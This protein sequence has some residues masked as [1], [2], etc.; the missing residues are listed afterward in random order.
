MSAVIKSD[1]P[2]FSPYIGLFL[3]AY[4]RINHVTQ[5]TCCQAH[6]LYPEE[7][8][9]R[10]HHPRLACC[11]AVSE[12][13]KRID[14][15]CN[16]LWTLVSRQAWTSLSMDVQAGHVSPAPA[17]RNEQSVEEKWC[18]VTLPHPPLGCVP[19]TCCR[20]PLPYHGA[21]LAL[22]V[23]CSVCNVT[24]FTVGNEMLARG[25]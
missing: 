3:L 6:H 7:E 8:N 1:F 2:R 10:M 15:A 13:L 17:S 21:A 19:I 11:K 14:H 18:G 16:H 5:E 20:L 22:F 4:L 12:Q 25:N 9:H 24:L 23:Q